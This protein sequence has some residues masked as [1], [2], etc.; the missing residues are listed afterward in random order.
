[1]AYF[2]FIIV[3]T[4]NGKKVKNVKKEDFFDFSILGGLGR[5]KNHEKKLKKTKKIEK[6]RF[7]GDWDIFYLKNYYLLILKKI[8]IY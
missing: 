4:I 2:S 6:I 1:M 8:I 7:W 5:I 3:V